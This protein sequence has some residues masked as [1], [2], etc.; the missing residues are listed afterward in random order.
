MTAECD[1][2]L[3]ACA[4]MLHTEQAFLIPLWKPERQ[5]KGFRAPIRVGWRMQRTVL[6]RYLYEADRAVQWRVW[7]CVSSRSLKA[8]RLPSRQSGLLT[9]TWIAQ[10][11]LRV[12]E[13][14]LAL[15]KS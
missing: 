12:L 14:N 11:A 13:N 15:T 7:R 6:Q 8:E 3:A 4:R 2:Y 1:L 10:E 5:K 9:P